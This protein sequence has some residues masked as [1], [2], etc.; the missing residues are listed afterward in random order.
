MWTD[1]FLYLLLLPVAPSI[2]IVQQPCAEDWVHI[3]SYALDTDQ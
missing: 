3:D 1:V 2:R